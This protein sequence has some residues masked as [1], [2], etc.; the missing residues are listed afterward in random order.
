[1][2][3]GA[4]LSILWR[5][6]LLAAAVALSC[7]SAVIAVTLSLP[8]T[9]RATAATSVTVI[10]A[11]NQPPSTDPVFIEQLVRTYTNLAGNANVADEVRRQLSPALTRRELVDRI[12]IAPIERTRLIEI[13]AEGRSPRDAQVLA[14]AY[15]RVFIRRVNRQA[16]A[17]ALNGR[18]SIQER[19]ALPVDPASPNPPLYIAFGLV[20]SALLGVGAALATDRLQGRQ[21][22][23][24]GDAEG[25]DVGVV[26]RI[27]RLPRRGSWADPVMEDAFGLLKTNIGFLVGKPATVILVTSSTS[28]EGKSSVA[29]QLAFAAVR[30]GERVAL[31]DA[32]LRDPDIDRLTRD[33]PAAR[34]DGG[35]RALLVGEAQIEDLVKL[36]AESGLTV[37]TAEPSSSNPRALLSSSQFDTMVG[38]LGLYYDRVIIDTPPITVGGDA[39]LA[40]RVADMVLF[41]VDHARSSPEM[42]RGGLDQLRAARPRSSAIVVNRAELP[43]HGSY[44]RPHVPD[45]HMD[46]VDGKPGRARS[47]ISR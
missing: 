44:G 16:A 32:D 19:A 1:M 38:Y 34:L 5:R 45:S 39:S 6:R 10:A 7:L 40:V 30:D 3:L 23:P 37:L 36:S 42:V 31:V 15:A 21:R 9:Y 22:S 18:V 20:L 14:D 33:V 43:Q 8:K 35:V 12:A 47:Q 46:V 24:G 29:S 27:P 2:D 41:V 17:N 13:N 25:F 11:G 26:G 4:V 28:G